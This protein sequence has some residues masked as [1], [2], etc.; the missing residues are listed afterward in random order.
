MG[1]LVLIPV[2]GEEGFSGLAGE[3]SDVLLR[4]HIDV[5]EDWHVAIRAEELQLIELVDR[6]EAVFLSDCLA[7]QSDGVQCEELERLLLE[8]VSHNQVFLRAIGRISR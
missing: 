2:V 6:H 7:I 8:V 3:G 5:I 1:D 4:G